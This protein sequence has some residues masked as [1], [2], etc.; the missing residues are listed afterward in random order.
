[1]TLSSTAMR[2]S[3]RLSWLRGVAAGTTAAGLGRESMASGQAVPT[4][5]LPSEGS[6]G[7]RTSNMSTWPKVRVTVCYGTLAMEEQEQR[8]THSQT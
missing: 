7:G 5:S 1:M 3:Q 8:K 4:I 2:S 6:P